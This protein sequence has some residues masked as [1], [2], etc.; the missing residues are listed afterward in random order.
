MSL[1]LKHR[2]V[3]LEQ[4][5]GN[6]HIVST[7][8]SMLSKKEHPHVFL[9]H[10]ETGC[11]KTSIGR[12]IVNMVGCVGSDYREVSS[13]DNRG[14][15]TVREI[16]KN[17]SY[18]PLEGKCRVWLLDEVHKMTNDAQNALLKILE[19]TPPHV[20]FILCTTEPTK[21]ILAIRGRCSEFQVKPLTETEMKGLL[22]GIVRS[23][24][25]TLKGEIYDQI[26]QDSLGHP[27][28]AIQTLEQVLN[29][30]PE[31]RLEVAMRSAELQ[32]QSIELCR[33]LFNPRIKWDDVNVILLQL[34]QQDPEDIRRAVLGYC[35]AILLKS[36]NTRAG[37]VMENFL[38]P[39]YVNGFP[40]LVF[41]A[42]STIKSK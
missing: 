26:I 4:I 27:R 15:D 11:G 1:Y 34:K 9:L 7:L 37:L 23:E 10:G 31:K 21:L 33:A 2:P 38:E 20:Y 42:Y 40:Q 29:V 24:G 16:I 25:E 32:S 30:E 6:E 13:N 36:D 8:N 12:I 28:N 35:Q 5:K 39:T 19:D 17:S 18:L 3:T 22:R 14:I 41:A